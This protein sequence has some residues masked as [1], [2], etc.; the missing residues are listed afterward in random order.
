MKILDKWFYRKSKRLKKFK[1]AKTIESFPKGK[2]FEYGTIY[3]HPLIKMVKFYCPCGRCHKK[4]S[5]PIEEHY[6]RVKRVWE[7][8]L[9]GDKITIDASIGSAN[10]CHSHYF[11]RNNKIDWL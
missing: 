11:I 1:I 2:E 5:L 4:E 3:Y 8:K 9:H 6:D 7:M 10:P